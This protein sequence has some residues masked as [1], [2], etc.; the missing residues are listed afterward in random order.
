[1]EYFTN[2][3]EYE[4]IILLDYITKVELDSAQVILL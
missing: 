3:E 1:M 4:I 2:F